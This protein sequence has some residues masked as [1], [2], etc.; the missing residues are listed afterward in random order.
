M[1]GE[2]GYDAA[3]FQE[4][5]ERSDLTRPAVNHYF[6]SKRALYREV[7]EQ[8]NTLVIAA[9]VKKAE[10]E[11]VFSPRLRAFIAEAVA[12]QGR[13][14]AVAAFL[15]TSVLESQRHPELRRDG[16]DALEATRTFLVWA[17]DEAVGAGEVR[18]DVD[19]GIAADTLVAMLWGLGFYAGFVG[20]QDQLV[21]V[22]E[23]FLRMLHGE[24][25][26]G[27]A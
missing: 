24:T 11:S 1:F 2:V 13:D 12:V 4:I 23:E 27:T 6:P 22:A 25:V 3:T 7:V 20:S 26:R 15:V 17:L 16:N 5:A 10:Q 8:T 9:G 19:V 18:A 21:A 14:P